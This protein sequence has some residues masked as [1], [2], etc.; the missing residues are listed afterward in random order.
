M[1][2]STG[3]G[4]VGSEDL[5]VFVCVRGGLAR[6]ALPAGLGLFRAHV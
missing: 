1:L 6:F 2:L 4:L 3:A 5:R